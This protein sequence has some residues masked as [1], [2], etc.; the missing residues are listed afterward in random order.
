M[1]TVL[2]LAC[3]NDSRKPLPRADGADGG[4]GGDG[5]TGRIGARWLRRRFRRRRGGDTDRGDDEHLGR[6][7]RRSRLRR[8]DPVGHPARRR[9][10]RELLDDATTVVA[11]GLGLETALVDLLDTVDADVIEMANHVDVITDDEHGDGDDA[12]DEDGHGHADDGDPHI[13]QDPRRVAGALDVIGSAV[14]AD[15]LDTC[16]DRYR[17]QLL[18]LDAEIE[19]RFAAIPPEQRVMVTSHDSFAYFADRYGVTVVGTVIPSTTTLAETNAADLAD[20]A[21]AIEQT[22]VTAVFTDEFESSADADALARRLGIDVVPLVTGALG[23]T[24]DTDTYVGMMRHNAELIAATM[25]S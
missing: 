24:S 1:R 17:D 20:L 25:S 11:N 8:R 13:W 18:A 5:G 21:E 6:H 19:Q 12:D 4:D 3:E 2:T 15:G 16:T 9:P 7:H 22:G 23:T 14:A 10:A